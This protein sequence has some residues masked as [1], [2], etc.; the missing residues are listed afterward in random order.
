MAH[1]IISLNPTPPSKI[2]IESNCFSVMIRQRILPLGGTNFL[3]LLIAAF[4]DALPLQ[5]R[6]YTLNCI[7]KKAKI[8]RLLRNFVPVCY[9]FLVLVGKSNITSTR[10]KLILHHTLL[11]TNH[12]QWLPIQQSIFKPLHIVVLSPD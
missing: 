12:H 8:I 7:I 11:H 9:L 5:I 4:A 6:I 3:T 1:F 10:I 2:S